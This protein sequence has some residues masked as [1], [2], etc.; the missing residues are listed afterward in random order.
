MEICS[1][2]RQFWASL[3]GSRVYADLQA[4][5]GSDGPRLVGAVS[6]GICSFG[7]QFWAQNCRPRLQI[8]IDTAPTKA[9]LMARPGRME[10]VAGRASAMMPTPKK[11]ARR[12][13]STTF[14]PVSVFIAI[15]KVIGNEIAENISVT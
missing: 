3:G 10:K 8:P 15:A 9:G 2:G 13:K 5:V 14:S 7:R 12:V 6:V 1:F 11:R 4:L